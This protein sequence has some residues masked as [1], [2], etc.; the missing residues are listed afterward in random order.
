[1]NGIPLSAR[2]GLWY[3]GLFLRVHGRVLTALLAR[4][5]AELGVWVSIEGLHG[6][7]GFE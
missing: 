3:T 5:R 2:G 1:M 6:I 4:V 7:L